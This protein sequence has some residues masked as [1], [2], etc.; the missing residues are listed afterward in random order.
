MI[1]A[2]PPP[3]SLRL[4]LWITLSAMLLGALFGGV[5][6]QP[7]GGADLANTYLHGALVGGLI[8]G[9]LSSI[10]IF[11]LRRASGA[12]FRQLPFLVYLGLRSLLY[13]GVILLI[14]ATVNRLMPTSTGEIAAVTRAD[15]FFSLALSLG[16]NLLYGVNALLGSGVLFAFVAGRYHRPRV[17]ERALL[18]IDMRSLHRDRRAPRRAALPRLPQPLHHRPV[19]RHRRGGRRDP[20]ICRRR[21][22]RHLEA[23]RRP[24]RGRLRARLFFRPRPPRRRAAPPMSANS[25]SA[26]ISAPAFIA[27]RWSSANSAISRRRSR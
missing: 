2:M 6:Y 14:E 17:E 23:R 18:F 22:H 3:K 21:D 12:P 8:G 11:V 15:V 7:L 25:A 5:E 26:P 19:A 13:L 27:V 16:Y 9:V 1:A 20:Q 4:V 24:E 10:E